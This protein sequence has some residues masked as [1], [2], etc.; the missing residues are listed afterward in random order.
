[1]TPSF[2]VTVADEPEWVLEFADVL[3]ALIEAHRRRGRI[4]AWRVEPDVA[5]TARRSCAGAGGCPCA[6]RWA[7]VPSSCRTAACCCWHRAASPRRANAIRAASRFC[8]VPGI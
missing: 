8:R 3:A 4:A 2:T 1:M 6:R 5:D 7:V